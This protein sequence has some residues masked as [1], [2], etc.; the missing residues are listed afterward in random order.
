MMND[1]ASMFKWT[2]RVFLALVIWREARGESDLGKIAVGY[3]ILNRVARPKWW[4][5]N[6][7][8]VLFKP[9]QYSSLTDP[10]DKQLTKWPTGDQV[11]LDCLTIA[12]QVIDGLVKNPVP[13]ADSYY[14]ISIEVPYWATKENFV[15]QIGRLNFHNVDM[16]I[17]SEE[18][19]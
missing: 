16:D 8:Q 17:Y 5:K 12:I 13:T 18:V 15:R 6:I 11:W 4:G 10:K 14:D 1:F 19:H 2:D 9:L 3:S 7:I